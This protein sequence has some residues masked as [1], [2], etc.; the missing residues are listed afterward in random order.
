MANKKSKYFL[1]RHRRSEIT[2]IGDFISDLSSIGYGFTASQLLGYKDENDEQNIVKVFRL[3]DNEEINTYANERDFEVN[4]Q[5]FTDS[6]LENLPLKLETQ[7]A[8]DLKIIN[9]D[10]LG[11]EGNQVVNYQTFSAFLASQL[12]VLLKDK[13]YERTT[14]MHKKSLGTIREIYN[15]VSVWCWCR[16]LSTNG[17]NVIINLSPFINSLNTGVTNQGGTFNLTVAPILGDYVNG[18]WKIR[19]NNIKATPGNFV[20]DGIPTFSDKEDRLRLETFYFNNVIQQ[21]DVIFVRFEKLGVDT[22]RDSLVFEID[23]SELPNKVYDM[24]GLVDNNT[25]S[26]EPES[27]DVSI[28]IQGRDL[29]KMF[30]EDGVYLYATGYANGGIFSNLTDTELLQRYDGQILTLFQYSLKSLD[31]ILKFIVNSLGNISIVNNDLF[32]AYKNSKDLDG[33]YRDRRSYS[34][35]ISDL[36]VEQQNNYIQGIDVNYDTAIENIKASRLQDGLNNADETLEASEASKIFSDLQDFFK[37]ADD[38]GVLSGS[39]TWGAFIYKNENLKSTG[40]PKEFR[41]KLYSTSSQF[42]RP[43]VNPDFQYTI[44]QLATDAFDSAGTYYILSKKFDKFQLSR[45]QRPLKGIWQIFKLVIDESIAK[46]RLADSS[47]GNENGSLINAIKK[48]CQEPWVEFFTDTYGD[49]F[50]AVIR[51]PPFDKNGYIDLMKGSV[52]IEKRPIFDQRDA[53]GVPIP[54][55]TDEV[56]I[57]EQNVDTMIYI[58]SED[59]LNVN[60]NF[61]S[62]VYSWYKLVPQNLLAGSDNEMAFAYLKAVYFREYAEIFGSKPLD[63][64]SNYIDFYPLKDKNENLNVAYFIQQG[65]RDLKFMIDTNAYLPFTRQGSITIN[66]DRRIKRGTLIYL[67]FTNE[68]CYVDAVQN[69]FTVSENGMI[70]RTTVLN[71]TR[72]MVKD[73]VEGKRVSLSEIYG[74]SYNAQRDANGMLTEFVN[75]SYFNIID[76]PIDDSIFLTSDFTQS[77]FNSVV[78]GSWFVNRPVFDFFIKRMQFKK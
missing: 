15:S 56:V 29:I 67:E 26:Y 53:N 33:R 45:E 1:Y 52:V 70:D 50:Y 18:D 62:E 71:L 24:I 63:I 34:Y 51:K 57:N 22:D 41:N 75:V 21:N 68:V 31:S 46:R 60:L 69:T 4:P 42:L 6:Q 30:I 28:S 61:S 48:V 49:Q 37:A 10:M 44:P 55:E 36:S 3:Y 7:L 73:F 59:V 43:S 23:E 27:N 25:I 64:V 40:I 78:S 17:K 72:C 9:N 54:S 19:D 2:T 13:K 11:V 65:M 35:F 47:I 16:S 58:K 77:D 76:T 5:L 38:A 39:G 14:Q 8:L 66:G 74:D 20:S 12:Y 32:K